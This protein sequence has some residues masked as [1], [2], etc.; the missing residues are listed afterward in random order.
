MSLIALFLDLNSHL[1]VSTKG[2][3]LGGLPSF[4]RLFSFD[5]VIAMLIFLSPQTLSG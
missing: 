3:S 2:G 1:S 4:S 5:V